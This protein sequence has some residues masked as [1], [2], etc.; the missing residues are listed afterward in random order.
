MDVKRH[1]NLTLELLEGAYWLGEFTREWLQHPKYSNSRPLLTTQDEFNIVQY[2]MEVLRSFQYWTLRMLKR[3]TVT[4]LY[5]ITVYNDMVDHLD[6]IMW[7]LHKK[8]N[9]WKKDLYFAAKFA[10]QTLSKY[11]VEVTALAGM[12][13]ISDH[14]LDCFRKLQSFRK[15]DKGMYIHPEDYTSY[16]TQY[17]AALLKNV[18]DEYCAKHRRVP[19]I[20]PKSVPCNNLFPSTM[21]A[22]SGQSWLIH[23]ICPVMMNSTQRL[24]M[25]LKRHLDKAI[26][27]H[28]DWPWPSSISIHRLKQQ[29]TGSILIQISWVLLWHNED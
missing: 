18:E 6:R 14:I 2:I 15:W 13:L 3:H 10:Q 21:A 4:L 7:S 19:V 28:A 23:M 29:R 12:I 11:Y 5:I 8:K 27:Q 25:W 16:S 9:R 22:G 20:K 1:W 24:T 26:A 17:Q